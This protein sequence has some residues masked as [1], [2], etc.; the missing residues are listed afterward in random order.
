MSFFKSK[1]IL[2]IAPQFFGY[3]S[4][5]I[6]EIEE[7]GGQVDWIPD[8]PFD[9]SVGKAVARFLPLIAASN[10]QTISRK[11]LIDFGASSYDYVLVIN[12]QTLSRSFLSELKEEFPSALFIL[13]LWDSVANRSHI[14]RN[15]HFFDRIFSFDPIDVASYGLI[16]RPLFFARKFECTRNNVDLSCDLSFVATVHSDRYQVV[17]RLKLALPDA[18]KSFFFLYIQSPSLFY[19]YRLSLPGMRRSSIDEFSFRPMNPAMVANIF[20]SSSSILDI[21]HPRQTGLTMR[22]IETLGSH[23]KLITTNASVRAYDFYDERNIAVIDRRC[24]VVDPAFFFSSFAP[25]DPMIERKYSV[26]GWLSEVVL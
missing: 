6:D 5:I 17:N 4:E 18:I 9:R 22:T 26:F 24:P 10:A 11:L 15:F 16:L 12:G 13:Y 1:R 7:Q 20:S 14:P 8:R 3:H 21:A 19:F 23:K 25:I 2:F